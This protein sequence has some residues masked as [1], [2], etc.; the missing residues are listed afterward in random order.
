MEGG[1]VDG[2]RRQHRFWTGSSLPFVGVQPEEA[3]QVG[4]FL[5][6]VLHRRV[7]L[8]V[9]AGLRF[10]LDLGK[11]PRLWFLPGVV[12]APPLGQGSREPLVRPPLLVLVVVFVQLLDAVVPVRGAIAPS[13]EAAVEAL[14]LLLLLLLLHVLQAGDPLHLAPRAGP[15]RT[16]LG[17]G[18]DH[19]PLLGDRADALLAFLALA[20]QAG[21]LRLL[22]GGVVAHLA[23][24]RLPRLLL[25][26]GHL[27]FWF[28]QRTFHYVL[29]LNTS[30][31]KMG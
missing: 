10:V 8:E 20:R 14:L 11:L 6:G 15:D 31:L 7:V 5:L 12:P 26:S 30:T 22:E 3:V 29:L 1:Q 9:I 21:V 2:G 13:L 17:A 19:L 23:P 28:L 16:L 18:A 24:S 27:F 25:T 4:L